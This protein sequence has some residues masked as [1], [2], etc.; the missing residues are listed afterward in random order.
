MRRFAGVPPE[1][2]HRVRL[3]MRSAALSPWC[4]ASYPQ[5]GRL[6]PRSYNTTGVQH[7]RLE[8]STQPAVAQSSLNAFANQTNH[9]QNLISLLRLLP[10][11]PIG[12]IRSRELFVGRPV[13]IVTQTQPGVSGQV[14]EKVRGLAI[15]IICLLALA[16]SLSD[17]RPI[18]NRFSND[19]ATDLIGTAK[20][21][22]TGIRLSGGDMSSK[23]AVLTLATLAG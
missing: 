21:W 22:L 20:D 16:L 10:D 18:E 2:V 6:D 19:I 4:R 13:P 1:A 11:V 7:T 15:P 14:A 9:F 5:S 17:L 23:L 8:T 3:Q 12:N